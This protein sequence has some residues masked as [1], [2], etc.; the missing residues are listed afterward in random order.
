[1]FKHEIDPSMGDDKHQNELNLIHNG[2]NPPFIPLH[3]TNN[4][5]DGEKM[6]C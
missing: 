1:M 2:G 5:P 4:D 3:M 6:R